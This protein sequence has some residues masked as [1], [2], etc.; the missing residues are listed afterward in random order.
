MLVW[1]AFSVGLA[2]SNLSLTCCHVRAV[3]AR[4]LVTS[5]P[6]ASSNG[7]EFNFMKA[8]LRPASTMN[9]AATHTFP[10]IKRLKKSER[11]RTAERIYGYAAIARRR[12]LRQGNGRRSSERAEGEPLDQGR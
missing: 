5:I 9:W 7:G 8:S 3:W 2:A 6:V 1:A 11:A 4:R 12:A 10:K